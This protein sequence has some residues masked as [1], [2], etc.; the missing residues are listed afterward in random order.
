M[1]EQ[2]LRTGLTAGGGALP[3]LHRAAMEPVDRYVIIGMQWANIGT[4]VP[5]DFIAEQVAASNGRAIGFASVNPTTPEAPAEFERAIRDLGLKG[6]KLSPAYQAFDPRIEQAW[7]L[8]EFADKLRVPIMFHSGGAY[9]QDSTLENASPALLDP[10]ARAFPDIRIIVA[11]FGQ[12]WMGETVMLMRKHPHV[13]ADLSARFHRPWQLYN[14][15]VLAMEYKVESKLLFGSDFP[16]STPGC[17]I[18]QFRTLNRMVEG[19]NLPQIP[20]ELV[21]SVLYHRPFELLGI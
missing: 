9:A 2:R 4:F 17:S 8:Y 14:G 11:H 20:D 7:R 21:E 13:Y 10:V 18:Q 3:E 5:N 16:A 6:L 12:P 19:T 1:V 15:L